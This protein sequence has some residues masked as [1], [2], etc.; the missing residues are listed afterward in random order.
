MIQKMFIQTP[1]KVKPLHSAK[2]NSFCMQLFSF[3]PNDAY[4]PYKL[5]ASELLFERK[6]DLLPDTFSLFVYMKY[7][8]V[9]LDIII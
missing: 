4:Y 8:F 3:Y 5:F 6:L 9:T 7:L 2:W 1:Q